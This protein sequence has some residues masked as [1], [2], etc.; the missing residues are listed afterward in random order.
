MSLVGSTDM[1]P[2]G[3]IKEIKVSMPRGM[4]QQENE[5]LNGGTSLP[6]PAY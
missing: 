5:R 2:S 6:V 1:A 4:I 3:E